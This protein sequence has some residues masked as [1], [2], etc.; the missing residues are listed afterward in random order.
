[1]EAWNKIDEWVD[2]CIRGTLSL[3]DRAA[4]MKWLETSPENA[5]QFRKI[6]QA[7]IRVSV[8]GKWRQLDQMQERVWE[9]IIP[10][11]EDRKR[12]WYSWGMRVAAI[13]VMM[14]GVLFV[15][16]AWQVP[17]EKFVPVAELLQVESGSPK[18]ILVTSMGEKIE[19]K[20]GETRQVA[21]IFGVG[22]IQDSTGG[23]RFED[24]GDVEEEIGKSTLVVPEK[25]EYFVVLGDGTK[26]WINSDSRLEFPNRFSGKIREV[27]L[28]GEAYFEVMPDPEKPFYVRVGESRVRV[29]GTAFNVMAYQE[30]RQTEVALLQGKVSVNVADK[31][32]MLVP[33]EIVT[34]DRESGQAI[35]RK[36]DVEAMVDWKAGRFNFEDMPLEKLTQR[37][38]RWYG[39]SFVFEDDMVKEL[40]FS[41]AVTKYR[42]LDYVLDM[43]SKTT[44]VE[45]GLQQGK[46]VASLKK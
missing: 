20:E 15:W 43:I 44:D 13:I 12:Q 37:L 35:V 46:V 10:V 23:V 18:A 14:I 33:G 4:L 11:L 5:E 2:R 24:K 26:V 21:E 29:L 22:V 42:T 6:F 39:V 19:L 7:K 8:A 36:G 28:K 32:Y 30:E 34:L 38:A 41:G 25:G 1:M 16:H 3:E 27:D 17:L 45:F 9:H 31:T 40:R